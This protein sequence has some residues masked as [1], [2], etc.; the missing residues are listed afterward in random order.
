MNIL[1]TVPHSVCDSIKDKDNI[2]HSCDSSAHESAILL[3]KSFIN[4]GIDCICLASNEFRYKHDLNRK[5]S[6][7]TEYRNTLRTI[8]KTKNPDILLDIHS[9]PN[10]YMDEA[11]DANMFKKDEIPPDIILLKGKLDRS[12]KNN[13]LSESLYRNL[14]NNNINV[15]IIKD[16]DVLDIINEASEINIPGIL[17]EINEKL[18]TSSN[19]SLLIKIMNIIEKT[20]EELY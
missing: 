19:H 13:S 2:N 11:R 14:K 7:K 5:E 6:R 1:L 9:Y 12:Y 8:M 18:T 10:N 3:C 15:K 4:K 16:I 17:I 20:I